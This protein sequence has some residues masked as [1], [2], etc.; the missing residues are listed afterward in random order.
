MKPQGAVFDCMVFVQAIASP[1]TA[2]R[3]YLQVM[4]SGGPLLVSSETMRELREV[5]GRP[6]LQRKLKGITPQRVDS[7][8][9]HLSDMAVHIEPVPHVFSFPPD[10]KDEPYLN[11]AIAA[12]AGTLV[13][14]DKALLRLAEPSNELASQ[15][16]AHHPTL[17]ILI[18]ERHLEYASDRPEAVLLNQTEVDP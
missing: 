6:E 9:H 5:L 11:L 15:L 12:K 8:L 7:L 4:D 17:R 14:R 16:A 10:P 13:T 3:C 2:H 18:P 1:G